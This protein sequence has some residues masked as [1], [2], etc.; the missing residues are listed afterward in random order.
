[1]FS[2]SLG[3]VVPRPL[4]EDLRKVPQHFLTKAKVNL[5]RMIQS[6]YSNKNILLC[7]SQCGRVNKVANTALRDNTERKTKQSKVTFLNYEVNAEI[8]CSMVT[9]ILKHALPMLAYTCRCD[10]NS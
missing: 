9:Q 2:S 6:I 3:S 5:Q 4:F 1:M 10:L 7:G 8:I